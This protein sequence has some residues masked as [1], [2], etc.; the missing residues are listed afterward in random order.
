MSDIYKD[1]RRKDKP[2]TQSEIQ[3][4]YNKKHQVKSVGTI[5]S[6]VNDDERALYERWSALP[7][8]K[9]AF[10]KAMNDYFDTLDK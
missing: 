3:A 9:E 7:K 10:I 2:M 6:L 1:L 4:R 5:L 8:K